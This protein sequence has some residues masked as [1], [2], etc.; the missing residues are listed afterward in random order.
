MIDVLIS[1]ESR[2]PVNRKLIREV[3][4]SALATSGVVEG[5]VS[6]A[7]VG[8]RKMKELSDTYLKDNRVHEVLSFTFE[9]P[10]LFEPFIES[11]DGV[12]R[13]GDI[14]VSY[15]EV[16][17]RAKEENKMVDQVVEF[18]IRHGCDHLLGRHHTE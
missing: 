3:V 6:V 9:D 7:I 1:S 16:V 2:Y 11:P 18:L 13:L 12:L 17:K 14:V 15:P 5:Q 4:N 10:A 8:R